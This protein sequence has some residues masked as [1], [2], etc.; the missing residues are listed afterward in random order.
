MAAAKWLEKWQFAVS[1]AAIVITLLVGLVKV[2]AM[3]ADVASQVKAHTTELPD[4]VSRT[5]FDFLR[6][7]LRDIRVDLRQISA[8]L[9]NK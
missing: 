2:S 4:K 9:Q 7:E 1:S 5:E 3:Y 8:T 6:E